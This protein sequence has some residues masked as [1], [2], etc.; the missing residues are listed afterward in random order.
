[1]FPRPE[2]VLRC[3][4]GFTLVELLVVIAIIGMLVGLLLPAIG[5]GR[6][7]ARRAECSNNLRQIGLGLTSYS[8]TNEEFPVGST[9][10]PKAI[11]FGLSWHVFILPHI[12]QGNIFEQIAPQPNGMAANHAADRI[13]IGI[14]TCPSAPE[15]AG[16]KPSHYVGVAGAGRNGA[17][18]DLEDDIC[19]DYYSD[20]VLYPRSHVTNAH[21][22]DGQS[23]TLLVGEQPTFRHPWMEGSYW[24]GSP[25]KKVCMNSTKNVRWPINGSPETF[26]HLG[27]KL[28]PDA[29][30][31]LSNDALF[32][33]F[34]PDGAHFTFAD[35]HV[36]LLTND[37]DLECFKHL[38]TI[39]GSEVIC[40]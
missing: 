26:G 10:I 6:E 28:P 27:P 11:T 32:S 37:I 9:I 35:G 40:P 2:V 14:Y 15:P 1:M 4:R 23:N 33:S 3:R 18:T 13:E 30:R 5:A 24:E 21:I 22:K 29:K 38:A 7:A 31:M 12:E 39:N 16:I 8:A 20:G 36:E 17:V 34:H 19:G 25:K